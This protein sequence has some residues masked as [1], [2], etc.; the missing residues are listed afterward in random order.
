VGQ[1]TKAPLVSVCM[2]THNH[3]PY[4]AQAIEGVLSQKTAFP[5]ELIIGEDCSTDAT[6]EI[7]FEYASC[8]PN[9][10]RVIT[11]E[12]NVGGKANEARV[13]ACARG[14][15]IAVC[16][17][18]DF[19]R[20]P[21]KL[22][23]QVEYLEAHPAVG[24]VHT[25][26]H[27]LRQK[28][29]RIS[30]NYF[31]HNARLEIRYKRNVA[32]PLL[33]QRYRVANCTTFMRRALLLQVRAADPILYESARFIMNDI[34]HVF[35]ISRLA[36]VHFLPE[37]Y[38]THRKLEESACFSKCYEK[39]KK[40][41]VSCLDVR[42]YLCEK[43]ALPAAVRRRVV[44]LF[45]PRLLLMSWRYSDKE[46]RN[47]L[48]VFLEDAHYFNRAFHKSLCAGRVCCS[49]ILGTTLWCMMM[50]RKY[51]SW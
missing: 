21:L 25:D 43:Y 20:E 40:F 9:L 11:S 8:H 18:D 14:R 30:R 45:L 23:H 2:I 19:W 47:Q 17:G 39:R 26:A 48:G 32:I 5:F 37:A 51:I 13:F 29:G 15:Y 12:T 38:A 6:R 3:E 42:M 49:C 7:V 27:L 28:T 41:N 44:N 1:S 46:L 24:L 50:W 34:P 33:E 36:G 16:E 10:I 35:E 22:Q 31:R 4:I